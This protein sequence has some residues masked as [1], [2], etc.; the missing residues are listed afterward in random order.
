MIPLL[1]NLFKG[2][3]EKEF[4]TSDGKKYKHPFAFTNISKIGAFYIQGRFDNE[5]E[6]RFLVKRTAD[7]YKAFDFE[8]HPFK[9]DIKYIVLPFISNVAEFKLIK[10]TVGNKCSNENLKIIK[11]II[12]STYTNTSLENNNTMIINS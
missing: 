11:N 8:P 1:S 9:D 6:Y 10:V 3:G 5:K 2:I 7:D 4:S 12:K